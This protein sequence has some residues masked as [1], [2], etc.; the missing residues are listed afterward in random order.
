LARSGIVPL[1]KENV[2]MVGAENIKIVPKVD[3][4]LKCPQA[5]SIQHFWALVAR[6]V[7]AKGWEA[8]NETEPCGRIKRQL[9]EID[10]TFGQ[11]MMRDVRTQLRNIADNGPLVFMRNVWYVRQ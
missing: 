9:K 7:Y 6:A 11:T 5:Q 10:I 3:N 8:K 1:C 4:P 2:G